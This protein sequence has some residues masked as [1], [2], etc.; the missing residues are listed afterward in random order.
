M[1]F[2]VGT[3]RC[4]SEMLSNGISISSR[5]PAE[6]IFIALLAND[7]IGVFGIGIVCEARCG[8]VEWMEHAAM[9]PRRIEGG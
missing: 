4:Y 1:L 6:W 7:C 9:L 2:D 3:V 5:I 8:H